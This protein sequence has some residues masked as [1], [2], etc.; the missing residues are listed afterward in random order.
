[1]LELWD[2]SQSITL[3]KMDAEYPSLA[4][5]LS[6]EASNFWIS[7]ILS[8][9]LDYCLLRTSNIPLFPL[10]G[11]THIPP[12]RTGDLSRGELAAMLQLPGVVPSLPVQITRLG[13]RKIR[14]LLRTAARCVCDDFRCLRRRKLMRRCSR[15]CNPTVNLRVNLCG[16]YWE[17]TVTQ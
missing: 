1:M 5:F 15:N 14:E 4:N 16:D 10:V 9:T 11:G 17:V 6:M 3:L 7:P 13:V 8:E 12:I 2:S